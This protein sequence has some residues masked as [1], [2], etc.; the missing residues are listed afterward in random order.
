[1]ANASYAEFSLALARNL[2]GKRVPLHAS[3]E[4][5]HRCPLTCSHCYNNLPMGDAAARAAELSLDEYRRLLDELADAGC[6]WL[7]LTG[8]EIL[9]RRDFLDIYTHAKQRGFLITL[10]TNGILLNEKIADH[11]ARYRPFA[12]EITLYGRTRETYERLTGVAGS[13]D[14]CL[15]GIRLLLDRKVP[16]KL[17]TVAVSVNR[18]EIAAMRRFAEDELGVAF[19]LDGAINP[20]IDCSSSPLAVRLTPEELVSIDLEDPARRAQWTEYAARFAGVA[21]ERVL[22]RNGEVYHCGGGVQ[23]FAVDPTGKMSICVLSQSDTWDLR[24]G[25][26]AEGWNHFL[27]AARA[28]KTT[29]PTKCTECGLK[30]L[31]G[32]CPANGELE[33]QDPEEPVDFLC[34]VGHLR[35]H[36]LGLAVPPHGDCEFCAGGTRH[37]ELLGGARAVLDGRFRS[38]DAPVELGRP[39]AARRLSLVQPARTDGEGD[40]GCA[41]GGCAS[42]GS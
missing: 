27:A 33:N 17:K 24:T 38:T 39:I 15:H 36:T 3:L 13:Y 40:G 20:R 4:L 37:D 11:L 23:S 30:S 32:M 35:A 18:H 31:C 42:C 22:P 21:P 2:A 26:F 9:A 16:L 5:T 34:H 8:G 41:S 12:V 6:L 14:R 1:M 28:K 29:R 10:F 19:K 7:L 25:G